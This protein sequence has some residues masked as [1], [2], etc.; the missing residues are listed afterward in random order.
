M[1]CRHVQVVVSELELRVVCVSVT[2]KVFDWTYLFSCLTSCDLNDMQ[3]SENV[4]D[5][6]NCYSL[7]LNTVLHFFDYFTQVYL[8]KDTT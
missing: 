2:E 8:L 6:I 7:N 1:G 4:D 5:W 3:F